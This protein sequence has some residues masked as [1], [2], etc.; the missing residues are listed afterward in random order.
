MASTAVFR[1]NNC[2]SGRS[3]V[4]DPYVHSP[5][6]N[7]P[8]VYLGTGVFARLR[9]AGEQQVNVKVVPTGTVTGESVDAA[10]ELFYRA[11]R[12]T[13]DRTLRVS[14]KTRRV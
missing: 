2:L 5:R 3:S 6:V 7:R 8:L 12:K 9:L 11:M 14:E 4:F 1:V 13:P 10:H